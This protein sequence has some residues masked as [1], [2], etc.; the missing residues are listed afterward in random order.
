MTFMRM[1][2]CGFALALGGS[3]LQGQ[4][5]PFGGV[6]AF[7][8]APS[9]VITQ[10]APPVV[11]SLKLPPLRELLMFDVRMALPTKEERLREQFKIHMHADQAKHLPTLPFQQL[12]FNKDIQLKHHGI[13]WVTAPDLFSI[14]TTTAAISMRPITA[15]N[16]GV[17]NSSSNA[18]QEQFRDHHRNHHMH[19]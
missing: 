9:T 15:M 12:L 1:I 5:V 18:R 4:Q 7:P 14:I 19:H 13:V 6:P 2:A 3:E 16:Q 11:Q 8:D 10:T 17:S